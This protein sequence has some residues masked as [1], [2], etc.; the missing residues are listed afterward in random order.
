MTFTKL[1]QLQRA[2]IKAE[3][4]NWKPQLPDVLFSVRTARYTTYHMGEKLAVRPFDLCSYRMTL[5]ESVF[6]RGG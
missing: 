2:V 1:I 3:E 5:F 4:E 6:T